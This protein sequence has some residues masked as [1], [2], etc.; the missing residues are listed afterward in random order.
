MINYKILKE[1]NDEFQKD[2]NRTLKFGQY[3]AKKKNPYNENARRDEAFKEIILKYKKKG[4][5]IPDLS[6]DSN[7]FKPSALLIDNAELRQ[8][9]NMRKGTKS[10]KPF[11]DKETFFISKINNM[12]YDRLKE[13]DTRVDPSKYKNL[14]KYQTNIF[15][16][17]L[18]CSGIE[19]KREVTKDMLK[20]MKK[21]IKELKQGNDSIKENITKLQENYDVFN[22]SD[23]QMKIKS[24]L[25]PKKKIR[26]KINLE[27]FFKRLS[28]PK[29]E[30]GVVKEPKQI[31]FN[32]EDI[33]K[34]LQNK[35]N[36]ASRESLE[37]IKID[38]KGNYIKGN[39][40]LL[41]NLISKIK[42]AKGA[43][44][45]LASNLMRSTSSTNF[46]SVNLFLNYNNHM[47]LLV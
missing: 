18:L 10:N 45:H 44:N 1:E 5:N 4:Y 46:E 2:I 17:Q 39:K 19:E 29:Y 22:D 27:E 20:D 24:I 41:T 12:L 11:E 7:L 6:T 9:F 33:F 21:N 36:I 3:I 26:T 38:E 40:R 14:E 47:I 31:L 37:P 32:S 16:A 25:S 34:R 15:Q 42:E 28:K 13:L 43:T 30:F 8:F 35:F 23:Y